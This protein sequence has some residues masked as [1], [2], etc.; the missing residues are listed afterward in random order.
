MGC[1]NG[2]CR[3]LAAALGEDFDGSPVAPGDGFGDEDGEGGAVAVDGEH[4]GDAGRAGG[5]FDGL[6]V[7]EAEALEVVEGDVRPVVE[8][9]GGGEGEVPTVAGGEG[10]V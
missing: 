10:G 9:A 7:E 6:A 1:A 3:G 8:E 5:G 2:V 4:V